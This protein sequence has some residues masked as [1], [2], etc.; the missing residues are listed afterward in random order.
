MIKSEKAYQWSVDTIRG[1]KE[2]FNQQLE[3]WQQ[4]GLSKEEIEQRSALAMIFPQKIE[5][6]IEE[7]QAIKLGKFDYICTFENIGKQLIR[8]RI[9]KGLS[10]TELAELLGVSPQ[11]VSKDERNEYHRASSEKIAQVLKALGIEATIHTLL[12]RAAND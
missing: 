10:Q 9:W 11:Q 4:E 2:A 12:E 5:L 6:E 8:F 7:Y 1:W 3:D